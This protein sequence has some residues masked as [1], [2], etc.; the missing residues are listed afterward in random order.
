MSTLSVDTITGQTT[1]ANVKLPAGSILQ[2]VTK[3][4]TDGTTISD[5]GT[6]FTDITNG[7][8][9][10]TPKYNNSKILIIPNI[11]W[12][13][14]ASNAVLYLAFRLKRLNANG[15]S[16]VINPN[17]AVD[18]TSGGGFDY[19]VSTDAGSNVGQ[20]SGRHCG[21]HIDTPATTSAVTYKFQGVSYG[22]GRAININYSAAVSGASSS[23]VAMEISV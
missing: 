10:I 12:L 9:S 8:I 15:T 14:G 20:F 17:V 23:I 2:T 5:Y 19:G 7:T 16:T 6:T 13:I 11:S 21:H 3:H 22:N 4:F 1:A 18:G